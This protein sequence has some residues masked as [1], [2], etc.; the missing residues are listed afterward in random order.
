MGAHSEDSGELH[1]G[2]KQRGDRIYVLEKSHWLQH[3]DGSSERR[4][5]EAVVGKE[6]SLDCRGAEETE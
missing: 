1:K 4:W 5:T 3:G 6:E 2:F